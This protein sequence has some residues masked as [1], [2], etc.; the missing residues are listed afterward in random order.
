MSAITSS[1]ETNSIY[2]SIANAISTDTSGAHMVALPNLSDTNNQMYA[3]LLASPFIFYT[4]LWTIPQLWVGICGAKDPS[5][6]M[7]YVAHVL[8]LVQAYV[9]YLL[10]QDHYLL[11][12]QWVDE[13]GQTTL[14]CCV[15]LFVVGQYLNVSVYQTLGIPGVYYGVRFGISIPWCSDFPYNVTWLKHPQYIGSILS[16][17]ACLPIIQL[18]LSWGLYLIACYV[19]MCVL[20]SYEITPRGTWSSSASSKKSSKFSRNLTIVENPEDEEEGADDDDD[21][22]EEEE[23][24]DYNQRLL[25]EKID[26]RRRSSSSS[27]KPKK[28]VKKAK[29][30]PKKEAAKKKKRSKS[31]RKSTKKTVQ[32][33]EIEDDDDDEEEEEEEEEVVVK[34]APR[35][36]A[37][38]VKSKGRSP[39]AATPKASPSLEARIEKRRNSG[40]KKKKQK[41]SPP[42]R[43]SRTSSRGRSKKTPPSKKMSLEERILAR[44]GKKK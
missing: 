36:R 37:S 6:Q 34:P 1:L 42:V 38:R 39:K 11:P 8:K 5:E 43:A 32:P 27:P 14:V 10:C 40:E 30:S 4:I 19:Y 31:T 35:R 2:V 41:K 23:D 13:L 33:I 28:K 26:K 22:G 18:P 25:V 21:D 17:V 44:S 20:E 15:F 24:D 29:K 7:S 16:V 3:I 12:S 9:F